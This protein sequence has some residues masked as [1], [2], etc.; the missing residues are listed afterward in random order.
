MHTQHP[1]PAGRPGAAI[2]QGAQVMHVQVCRRLRQAL[3]RRPHKCAAAAGAYHRLSTHPTLFPPGC[4]QNA[5]TSSLT[6]QRC[7]AHSGKERLACQL[8]KAMA[9]V[10]ALLAEQVAK[11]AVEVDPRV[12]GDAGRQ[13]PRQ[14]QLRQRQRP[15]LR[16]SQPGVS[17]RVGCSHRHDVQLSVEPAR[18]PARPAHPAHRA[19]SRAAAAPPALQPPSPPRPSSC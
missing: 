11:V 17:R 1:G 2:T 5:I 6:Y 15:S 10:G 13:R 18:P 14:Q 9:N 7:L 12:S 19:A 8:D 4:V 3:G 16:A